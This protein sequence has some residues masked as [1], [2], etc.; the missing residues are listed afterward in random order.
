MGVPALASHA[1]D[2]VDAQGLRRQIDEA[3]AS[4]SWAIARGLLE[5]LWRASPEPATAGFVV[6]RFEKL[7]GHVPL[8]P[9][10]L[11]I[12]R[13]FTVEPIVPLARAC[14]FAGGIDLVAHVGEF[15]AYAQELL[16]PADRLYEFKPDV[17]V[18]AVQARDLVPELWTRF[19]E[20]SPAEV[21]AAVTRCV[22]SFRGWVSALRARSSA[23]LIVHRL[24]PPRTPT[25][26]ILDAQQALGQA[27]AIGRIN[28]GIAA[29]ARDATDVY[30]LDYPA[31][32]ARHGVER[33]ADERKWLTVRL[34]ISSACLI[35]MAREWMRFVHPLMGKVAK[36]IVLDLD[37]T[38][39]GGVIGEDGMAGIKLDAEFPGAAFQAVQRAAVDLFARGIIIAINSKNNPADAKEAIER[40]RGMILRPEHVAAMRINWQDKATN[41]REIAAELNIGV[42][43]LC[44][45][46]DNPVERQWVRDNVPEATV[47]ELPADPMGYAQAIRDCPLFERLSLSAEDRSRGRYYA[48]E[49]L[50]TEFESATTNV[51]EFLASLKME[52]E[53]GAVDAGTLARVSQL[54]QKTNQFNLTTRRYSEQQV[55]EMAAD[56][57]CGVYWLRLRDRFGDN[58]IIGVGISR[59]RGSEV[60]I[61]TF[62]LSCRVIGRGIEGGFLGYIA[63]RAR[64]RGARRVWGWFLPT[65][66]NAP[67][68]DFYSS[69]GFTPG[70][71]DSGGGV[72]Y[73]YDLSR[74]PLPWPSCVALAGGPAPGGRVEAPCRAPSGA[75]P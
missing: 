42:D 63:E 11:A 55:K 39:W 15:N 48:E 64:E 58:G 49:R 69:V 32:V 30:V 13:S 37:N 54:T 10:R 70:E 59:L 68:K 56:P 14:A 8:T 40:H 73:E 22:E 62:L 19:A 75:M 53:I 51:E 20:L 74:G 3:L 67:C 35:H 65:K 5:A 28:D 45:V 23:R 18:L 44:F 21:E 6:G 27:S 57:S 9:C 12:L 31:L 25:N 29:V 2:N 36:A 4:S 71:V 16:N 46:D 26:G 24:E 34:P 50:R 33:W 47:L 72:R 17:V 38:I 43:A 41:L 7:R 52:A 61:D 1:P 66:K 60:E